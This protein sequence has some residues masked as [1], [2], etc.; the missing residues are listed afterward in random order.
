[1][2]KY[3]IYSFGQF[4]LITTPISMQFAY[5]FVIILGTCGS[6]SS[7]SYGRVSVTT[8]DDGDRATYTCNSGFTVVGPSTRTCLSDGSWSESE[9]ICNCMFQYKTI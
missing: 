4:D 6:L 8:H 3:Y 7:P 5:A 9:P 1:M 2:V